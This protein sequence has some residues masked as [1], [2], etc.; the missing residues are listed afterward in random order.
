MEVKVVERVE[1][2]VVGGFSVELTNESDTEDAEILYSDS[3]KEKMGRLS[4]FA[5]NTKEYCGIQNCMKTI[6]IW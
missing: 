4:N 6:N 3:Y 2:T 1:E 5:K